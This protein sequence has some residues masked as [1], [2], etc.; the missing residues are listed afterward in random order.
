MEPMAGKK[1]PWREKRT[2][3]GKKDFLIPLL[4]LLLRET[5]FHYGLISEDCGALSVALRIINLP[6]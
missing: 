6:S 2:P 1:D 5:C 4:L 3:G